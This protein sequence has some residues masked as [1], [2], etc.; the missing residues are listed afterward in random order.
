[1]A[2]KSRRASSYMTS[3]AIATCSSHS[4]RDLAED[5]PSFAVRS[6]EQS[7]NAL[8]KGVVLAAAMFAPCAF[9]QG[10]VSVNEIAEESGLTPRQVAM[11]L[12]APTSYATYRTEY[13]QARDQLVRNV[14]QERYAEYIAAYRSGELGVEADRS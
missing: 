7:M 14:G 2:T 9:A 6:K 11:V 12:G 3:A 5:L 1:M 13:R 4:S 8:P 10:T